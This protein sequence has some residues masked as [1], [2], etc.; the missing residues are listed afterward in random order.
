MEFH[1]FTDPST[2]QE[3]VPTPYQS[4]NKEGIIYYNIKR[5]LILYLNIR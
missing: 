1:K 5:S 4:N 3:A 2:T